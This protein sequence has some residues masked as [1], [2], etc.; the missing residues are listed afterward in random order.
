MLSR[1][2]PDHMLLEGNRAKYVTSSVFSVSLWS[3]LDH[4]VVVLR[5]QNGSRCPSSGRLNGHF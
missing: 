2:V 1:R 3:P 5:L 4:L